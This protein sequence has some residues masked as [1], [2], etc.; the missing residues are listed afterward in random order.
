MIE[1]ATP[2][3]KK[4]IK[5]VVDEEHGIK[6]FGSDTF[7]NLITHFVECDYDEKKK[8][9]EDSIK[10]KDITKLKN[11]VHKIKT[12]TMYMNCVDLAQLCKDIEYY[13]QKGHENHQIAFE[14]VPEFLKYFAL[15][16]EEANRLYR[17]KYLNIPL[18]KPPETAGDETKEKP[19]EKDE[20]SSIRQD[21]EI[22]KPNEISESELDD[23]HERNKSVREKTI[24]ELVN[25]ER[26]FLKHPSQESKIL[27]CY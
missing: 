27:S 20:Y 1:N 5:I 25:K 2:K 21:T 9:L 3:I 22:R 18:E 14:M 12:L 13:T 4:D 15:L 23:I 26:T 6:E 16:Y 11:V 19:L 24:H 10:D 7:E 17:V 8:D